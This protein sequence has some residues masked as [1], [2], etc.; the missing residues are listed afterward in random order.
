MYGAIM[1]GYVTKH[2]GLRD[3]ALPAKKQDLLA[4]FP[5]PSMKENPLEATVERRR[6]MWRVQLES[7]TCQCPTPLRIQTRQLTSLSDKLPKS[8]RPRQLVPRS[9][10]QLENDLR[11]SNRNCR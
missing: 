2:E 9:L 5:E 4:F 11:L 3:H 7:L 6:T 1:K 10:G 8:V